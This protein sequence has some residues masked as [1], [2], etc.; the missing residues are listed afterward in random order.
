[1]PVVNPLGVVMSVRDFPIAFYWIERACIEN[2][3][4]LLLIK[5]YPHHIAHEKA[6]DFFLKHEEYTHFIIINEDTIVT[7]SHLK[8]L[9]EDIK[10]YNY[11]VIGSFCFP[12]SKTHPKT[13]LTRKNMRNERV[14]F[15]NQYDFIE[16]EEV[17]SW[18]L[19]EPLEPFYFNGL[20]LTAIRRDIVEK[21]EFKP[22]KYVND[23]LL[24]FWIRR[25]IMFDLQ[26]SNTLHDLGIPLMVDK[27]LMVI[28]FGNTRRFINLRGKTPH[29]TLIKPYGERIEIE[30]GKP[31]K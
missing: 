12:Y 3:I 6:R 2:G 9:I 7:P 21:V 28:H 14:V 10:K 29:I 11:P 18:D 26:F 23:R 16:L 13:N 19:S 24:G 15:A 8:L 4:D 27:R 20:A 17:I 31:Y 5:Y 25:G 1:M 30:K 22:Y